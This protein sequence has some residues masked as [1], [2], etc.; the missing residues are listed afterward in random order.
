MTIRR[1]LED[2]AFSP[3]FGRQ[4]RFIAGPRQSGKTTLARH[5]L[6]KTGCAP[7]CYN[8]DNRNIREAY[9]KDNHFFMSDIYNVRPGRMADDG[10]ALMRYTSSLNGKIS[11]RIFL[12]PVLKRSTLL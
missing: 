4:M 5:F 9:L 10:Y 11:S 6:K 8:W 7:L 3:D 2:I 1:H 12:I